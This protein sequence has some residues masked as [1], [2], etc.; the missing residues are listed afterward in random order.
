MAKL[1]DDQIKWTLILDAKGVQGE[2]NMLSSDIRRLEQDNRNLEGAMAATRKELAENEKEMQKLEK[3]GKTSSDRYKELQNNS[4]ALRDNIRELKKEIDSNNQS[5]KN[6]EKSISDN[7]KSMKLSDMTMAQ[8]KQ[9]AA[10]LK[11]QLEVTSRSANPE[12]YKKLNKELEAVE[13]Q[14]RQNKVSSGSLLDS[15]ETIPGPVGSAAKSLRGL[16]QAL[17]VLIANP[18]GIFLMAVVAA[19]MLLKNIIEGNKDAMTL[20]NGES[21]AL[22]SVLDSLK[23]I[24]TEVFS[25][26]WNLVTLDFEGM[27]DNAN[28]IADITT[29]MVENASAA[30]QAAYAEKALEEQIARNNSIMAVN[31]AYIAEQRQKMQDVSLS[32]KERLAASKEVAEYEEKNYKMQLS[33][34]TE[35]YDVF[36]LKNANIIDEIKRNSGAQYAEME[37]Y[38]DLIQSGTELTLEQRLAL[39]NLV[40]D[41]TD[42]LS[43]ATDE[44]REELRKL[45]DDMSV[46]QEEYHQKTREQRNEAAR[47]AFQAEEK[48]LSDHYRNLEKALK[49]KILNDSSLEKISSLE[50][51]EIKK[52]E[53]NDKVALYRKYGKEVGDILLEISQTEIDIKNEKMNQEL[54]GLDEQQKQVAM[55]LGQQYLDG[56]KTK[57]EYEA[58]L[59]R[60]SDVHAQKKLEVLKK[61]GADTLDAEK[62]VQ[63]NQIRAYTAKQKEISKIQEDELRETIQTY[64]KRDAFL[65]QMMQQELEETTRTLEQE[66]ALESA[67]VTARAAVVEKYENKRYNLAVETEEKVVAA[68]V[69]GV[70]GSSEALDEMSDNVELAYER[71]QNA[72]KK[73]AASIVSDFA[74]MSE[75]LRNLN[76]DGTMG[77][78]LDVFAT[79]FDT[80]DKILKDGKLDW[81][82]WA[83]AILGVMSSSLNAI[84]SLSQQTFEMQTA[85]LEKEK[86]EQLALVGDN[87]EERE[88]IEQE[89]AEKELELQK[90][91]ANVDA[92]IQIAQSLIQL[93]TGIVTIWS[94]AMQLGPIAGPIMAGILSAAMTATA[95]IQIAMI[96]KQRQA[97]QS[98]T[99]DGGGSSGGSKPTGKM[100]VKSGYAEGGYTGNGGKYEIAGYLPDGSP[101][102]KGEYIIAQEELS[103]PLIASVVR[104]IEGVRRKRTNANAL[105]DSIGFADGGYTSSVSSES[106]TDLATLMLEIKIL[107]AYLRDN[108]VRAELNYY[109]FEDTQ[110]KVEY[111]RRFSKK[112]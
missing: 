11:S 35:A 15:F 4:S 16:G 7:I 18:I 83:T 105:P 82:D 37:K 72:S 20:F 96:N 90:K 33:N 48:A 43:N 31:N 58:S 98:Q 2:I 63:D 9:R 21:Q 67:I 87:A 95:G 53:L 60:L 73:H 34:L 51:L 59:L 99:L 84:Q 62:A 10:E 57:E 102:H 106:N 55:Q 26:L 109:E 81:E 19:F 112:R 22:S 85:A 75:A 74:Y 80:I 101:Y 69:A 3:A 89:Y 66:G 86:N 5:I 24:A 70:K 36:K 13:D 14:M 104:G 27:K 79:T 54:K 47:V 94:T 91:Q 111:F 45:V 6:H 17:K 100:V 1:T 32:L 52:K 8:L 30:F 50:L 38:M 77:D 40:N 25:L 46:I 108:G 68:V 29:S 12:E 44:Q 78:V 28:A 61:Y 92:G 65:K 56:K 39:A 93:A 107:L 41:I 49:N 103:N 23:R 71:S 64:K 110:K 76:F 88:K 42:N 97:I